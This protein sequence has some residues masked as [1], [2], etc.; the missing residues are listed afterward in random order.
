MLTRVNDRLFADGDLGATIES[1]QGK[2][3][4]LVDEIAR[5]QVLSRS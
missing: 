2:L 5:D 1:H 3:Q 4:D